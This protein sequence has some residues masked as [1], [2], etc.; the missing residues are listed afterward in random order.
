MYEVTEISTLIV[1]TL[2]LSI[3]PG[4]MKTLF[5]FLLIFFSFNAS[6]QILKKIGNKI[7]NKGKSELNDAKYE[8]KR[9][10]KEAAQKELNNFTADFDSTDL[11]YAILVSDNSGLFGGKGKGEFGTKFL[12]LAGVARSLYKDADLTDEENARL[13]LQMAQSGYGM[14]KLVFAEKRFRAAQNF[15]EKASLKDDPGYQKTISGEGLLFTTMGRFRLAETFMDQSLE[16]RKK[17]FG[18]KDMGV[19]ACYNNYAVLHYNLGLYNESEKDFKKA[20]TVIEANSLQDAMPYAIVLNNQAML[21]Q[22]IGRYEA[23]SKNLSD[24][25]TIAAHFEASKSKNHL[26]FLSNMALLYQQMGKYP[27]AEAIYN[28][29]EKQLGK[30]KPEYA[31]ML[32]NLAILLLVMNKH[33]RIEGLLQQSAQIYLTN[34]G[35]DSPAYAKV[36][37]DL[38]NFYRYK[39]RYAE[40]EPLLQ[41]ALS[42][43][44]DKLGREHPL[45]VQSEEDMAILYWKMK[46]F[47]KARSLYSK[48]MDGSLDF[49]NRY[50]PPMNEAEKTKYW[51]LLSPRFER[52]Y[53][54]AIEAKQEEGILTDLFEYRLATKGLLL[55]SSKKVSESI[56]ASGNQQLINDY[57][58]WIDNKEQLATLYGYSKEE[59][60]EQGV[61]IDSLEK[62]S[63]DM[64]KNL[65]ENSNEFAQYYYTA[66][67]SYQQVKEA[68]K[69]GE[70]LVEII[71][72]RNFDQVLNDSS[73]YIGMIITREKPEPDVVVLANGLDLEG[74]LFAAYRRAITS[75]INDE[76]SYGYFW[77]PINNEIKNIKTVYLSAD[78]VYNQVNINTLKNPG[79]DYLIKQYNIVLVGN[80]K[81]LVVNNDRSKVASGKS[82]ALIGSPDFASAKIP[83][84]PATKTEVD[85]ISKLLKSSGYRVSEWV[86]K[87]ATE[88][89]L[90]GAKDV[91]IL[92]IATHGYFL[93]NV[94]RT[95]WPIGVHSD[96]AKDNILLR[97]GLLLT[98]ALETGKDD[99]GLA[100][101]SNGVITSY[102]A[103]NLDL[104]GT[105]LVVL[106][107]CETGLGEIKAGEGVYGLQRAFLVAGA[108]A[109]IMSLWKVNDEAT[110]QLMNNFYSNW[111]HT[112][113]MQ[114]SF[115]EAQLQ[116]MLKYKEPYYWGAFVLMED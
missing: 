29:L 36:I 86:Q 2:L 71:R 87:E 32:N 76:K 33:E 54:F 47:T 53:N 50:F 18:E 78:G 48:V 43:R 98:G 66:K 46:E 84:L 69:P 13:N 55:S 28:G 11:D 100:N 20:L 8:A 38:G 116:L 105:N 96:Y 34:L 104:R 89:N 9:K 44:E 93:K 92:H 62:V 22:S 102:E 75:K 30:G 1:Q 27:E 59:L 31:N 17:N 114:K 40:A 81:D 45:F 88:N 21:F 26:R 23:A 41:K 72:A 77:A 109:L 103:M 74:K 95:N 112:S 79:A 35:E 60:A 101:N 52:F 19:A 113:D 83:Q 108:R 85:G 91:S 5:G 4:N 16:I 82:A 57:T 7:V 51:D 107:A 49:I 115:R 61:N 68:L 39:Y 97:S 58:T 65:S 70:A 3:K 14:G 111:I 67:V 12:R 63:N 73:R 15:F 80:G 94:Q 56:F 110:Q 90:K 6:S 10:A 24:A 106:S 37:S 42:I 25:I 64:E 99:A